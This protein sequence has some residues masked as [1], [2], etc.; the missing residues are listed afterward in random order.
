MK[1][2]LN[3]KRYFRNPWVGFLMMTVIGA[4]MFYYVSANQNTISDVDMLKGSGKLL[5]KN[6]T[7]YNI[8][9][10]GKLCGSFSEKCKMAFIVPPLSTR[11][12][13]S[14]EGS[15]LKIGK[16]NTF[17]TMGFALLDDKCIN[18]V[19][20]FD[21]CEGEINIDGIEVKRIWLNDQ[22][23][24]VVDHVPLDRKEYG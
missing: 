11:E 5:I 22:W 1:D 14:P 21:G 7:F 12:F 17:L 18:R 6:F 2:L 8:K 19:I 24:L 4:G 23:I 3:V 15:N 10:S 9:V 16:K 13:I 20:N